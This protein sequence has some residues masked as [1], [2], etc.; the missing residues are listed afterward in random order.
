MG[1]RGRPIDLVHEQ[2]VGENRP[3]NEAQSAALED[4]GA[5]DVDREEIR[6]ALD[7]GGSEVECAGDR[8]GKQRLAGARNV[9]DE[10]VAVGQQGDRDQPEGLV[11]A[12][13]G[14][15][16]GAPEVVPQLPAGGDDIGPWA[17]SAAVAGR[18]VPALAG[19][20]QL[21]LGVRRRQA[22]AARRRRTAGRIP[23]W[24]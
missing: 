23:P 21:G 22:S 17:E 11:G 24:R 3:R 16:D 6:G 10:D 12:D 8:P 14:E 13:D 20:Q 2:D 5:G 9:L 15:P 18:L 7:S 19:R 4:A 1:P